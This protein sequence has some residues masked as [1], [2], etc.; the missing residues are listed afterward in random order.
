MLFMLTTYSRHINTPAS[1]A[2]IAD[3]ELK[4]AVFFFFIVRLTE[5]INIAVV[6][7]PSEQYLNAAKANIVNVRPKFAE[8]DVNSRRQG[9]G[10]S[11]FLEGAA[12]DVRPV[13]TGGP[14]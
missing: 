7:P 11:A 5:N 9:P 13:S 2:H 10:S 6:M 14:G 1:S 12:R 4:T 8:L 3:F